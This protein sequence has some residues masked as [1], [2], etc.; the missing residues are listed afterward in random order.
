MK[1]QSFQTWL[2]WFGWV[3][4]IESTVEVGGEEVAA[5]YFWM[6]C[7]MT[8]ILWSCKAS[9]SKN[10][11]TGLA[12]A[13]CGCVHVD[14]GYLENSS[15]SIYAVSEFLSRFVIVFFFSCFTRDAATTRW[16]QPSKFGTF[17]GLLRQR[18]S[19]LH[20]QL[21]EQLF[22]L[23]SQLAKTWGLPLSIFIVNTHFATSTTSHYT[24][25]KVKYLNSPR[26]RELQLLCAWLMK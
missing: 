11:S 2:N 9:D 25:R 17:N 12:L 19:Y 24:T 7:L 26:L 1:R 20:P 15:L 13:M 14:E 22:N 4:A 3:L 23:R 6:E 21:G 16:K 8:K 10:C 18:C 5:L